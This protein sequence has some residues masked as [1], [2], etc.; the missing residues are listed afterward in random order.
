MSEK[1]QNHPI[2]IAINETI[3]LLLAGLRHCLKKDLDTADQL[4]V[5]AISISELI[6]WQVSLMNSLKIEGSQLITYKDMLNHFVE[7]QTALDLE[8]PGKDRFAVPN[9]KMENKTD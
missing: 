1:N 9:E 5:I 7:I 6:G 2:N 8:N 4:K 3:K